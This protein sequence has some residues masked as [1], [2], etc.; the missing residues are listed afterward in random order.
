M[1]RVIVY[2]DDGR[3]VDSIYLDDCDSGQAHG[4]ILTGRLRAPLGFLGRA[5]RDAAI[6]QAGG[7]P[8]RLSEKAMRLS[9]QGRAR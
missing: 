1:A 6:I 3:Y 8:E 2:T 7:D 5:L 4:R 9:M